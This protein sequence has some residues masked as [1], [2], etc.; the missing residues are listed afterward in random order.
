MCIVVEAFVHESLP[1]MGF[2][3]HP[4]R[5]SYSKRTDD[6]ADGTLIFEN[7]RKMILS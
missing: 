1:V 4:E 3:W 5:M 7:F 6:E 2:Q